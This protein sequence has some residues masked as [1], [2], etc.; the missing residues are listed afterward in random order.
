M[1]TEIDIRLSE[2]SDPQVRAIID[3]HIAHGD[4]HYPVES[5]HHLT[6]DAH[7][8]QEVRL[9]AAWDGDTCLG[10]AG[11][12]RF[13]PQDG[14]LKSMHV[15]EE[16]RGRG[17]GLKLLERVMSEARSQGLTALYLETGSR[18][19]SAAARR[20]YARLEFDYCSP[21]GSYREDVESVFMKRKL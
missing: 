6:S 21:F 7:N 19:A 3:T 18:E 2:P 9:F 5:N 4:A 16:A 10:I 13:G 8:E 1:G 17:V 20:L 15:R 11:L 14:E 12:K